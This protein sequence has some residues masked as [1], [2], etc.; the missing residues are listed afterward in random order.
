[1]RPMSLIAMA[2]EALETPWREG[3]VGKFILAWLATSAGVVIF[4]FLVG[5]IMIVFTP[6]HPGVAWELGFGLGAIAA[7]TMLIGTLPAMWLIARRTH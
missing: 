2:D 5:V 3:S 6:T 1:M 7:G 4:S